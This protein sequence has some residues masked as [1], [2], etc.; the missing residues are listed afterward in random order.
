[1]RLGTLSEDHP[2]R[3][4]KRVET[5]AEARDHRSLASE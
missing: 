5:T 3:L 4:R 1:M 2:L